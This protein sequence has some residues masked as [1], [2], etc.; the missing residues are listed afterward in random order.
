M[1]YLLWAQVRVELEKVSFTDS[2]LQ[3]I[4]LHNYFVSTNH[5]QELFGVDQ[6]NVRR[7]R[8]T[9]PVSAP[10]WPEHS[11]PS[12]LTHS[13]QSEKRTMLCQPI[14][15]QYSHLT[16]GEQWWWPGWSTRVCPHCPRWSTR[17]T[18][19]LGRWR[20]TDS[21]CWRLRCPR[22]N[23]I[24]SVLTFYR[25]HDLLDL[26]ITLSSAVLSLNLLELR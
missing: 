17:H 21:S 15:R 11:V 24:L 19:L 3:P 13:E 25:C 4:K 10:W 18:A 22:N 12:D 6:S 20:E 2:Q 26:L 8:L 9:V 23:L 1:L 16:H 5:N 7:S 14:R